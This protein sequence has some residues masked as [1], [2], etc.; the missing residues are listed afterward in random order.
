L[1][2]QECIRTQPAIIDANTAVAKARC[3]VVINGSSDVTTT[4]PPTR[5]WI[6]MRII[7]SPIILE[8]PTGRGFILQT[9]TVLVNN[10]IPVRM[11]SNL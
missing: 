9:N 3:I 7:A 10:K 11:V 8:P 6:M 4:S 1:L 2:S 5:L